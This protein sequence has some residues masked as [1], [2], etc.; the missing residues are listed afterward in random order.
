MPPTAFSQVK[1]TFWLV[2]QVLGSNQCRRSRRFYRAT[3]S[4]ALTCPFAPRSAVRGA[5]V[6]RRTTIDQIRQPVVSCPI[7]VCRM[8]EVEKVYIV[9]SRC[10]ENVPASIRGW[11]RESEPE[12]PDDIF[13]VITLVSCDRCG[14]SQVFLQVD[15]GEGLEA[16][17]RVWP[18]PPRP[19]LSAAVPDPLRL[20]H[21]E[22]CKCF[23]TRAYTAAVVMVG[24]TLEAVCVEHGFTSG[25]LHRRLREMKDAGK[26]DDRL[27]TW[28]D[29][30]R[31]LRNQGAH[32]SPIRVGREDAQDA[33]DLAEALLDYLYVL[34]AKFEAFQ[35]RRA[36]KDSR[37]IVAAVSAADVGSP[38]TAA[39][40]EQASTA[41]NSNTSARV[42]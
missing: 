34:A 2:W 39:P 24:R 1:G 23:D 30:L 14:S 38:S 17:A 22:A 11:V 32:Y 19:P 37:D 10:E 3:V 27:Y 4:L 6:G 42:I 21:E 16:M 29:G 28:A 31:V 35:A 13:Y 5:H 25:P 41:P 7:S 18:D 26:I 36:A 8:T 20:E 33:L 40:V 12:Y 9:C 15:Q